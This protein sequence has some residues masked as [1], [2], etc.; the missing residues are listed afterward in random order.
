MAKKQE[1]IPDYKTYMV[2][3]EQYYR[4]RIKDAD[5]KQVALYSKTKEDL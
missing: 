1:E 3:G 5:G 4:T 2:K